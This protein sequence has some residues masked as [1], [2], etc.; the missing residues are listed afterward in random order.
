LPRTVAAAD[1]PPPAILTPVE[2][3][4][5]LRLSLTVTYRMLERGE[6]PG[7]KVARRWRI[8]REDIESLLAGERP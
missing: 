2:A 6:L 7:R 4:E 1:Q 5:Y 3:A 8:R